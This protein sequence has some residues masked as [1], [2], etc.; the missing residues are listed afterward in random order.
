MNR[1]N[2]PVESEGIRS[3]SDACFYCGEPKGGQHL[4]KC[5]IRKR[6]VVIDFT[7]RMVVAEPEDHLWKVIEGIYDD[8]SSC[9]DNILAMIGRYVENH[10]I[11][12]CGLITTKVVRE[13]TEEDEKEY[14]V[15]VEELPS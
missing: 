8:S 1:A 10:K 4:E 7:I 11:C 13:A 15:F 14:E 3:A 9:Q 5:V 6:T 2:W 12:A